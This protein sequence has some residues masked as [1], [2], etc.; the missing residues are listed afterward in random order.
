M[1]YKQSI[2]L[3][4]RMLNDRTKNDKLYVSHRF[5]IVWIRA[6]SG[7]WNIAGDPCRVNRNDVLLLNN[8]EKRVIEQVRSPEDLEFFI[9]E[10]EPQFLFDSGLLPLFTK[11]VN[12]YA[13]RHLA[14]DRQ[15]LS[16]MEQILGERERPDRYSQVIIASS[17]LQLLAMTARRIGL[18]PEDTP[19]VNTVMKTVLTYIDQHY[20]ERISLQE[21]ADIAHMS[22]TAFSRTFTKYNGIGP[23]QYI[24]RK[25]ILLATRLLEETDRTIVDIAM[26]CGYPNMSNFYKAFYSLTRRVPGSYR[27]T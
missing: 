5:K 10:F 6:G 16:I 4:S 15:M 1:N 11:P 21:L 2:W 8:K 12:G 20:T 27:E 22:S 23:A 26:E 14:A 7:L 19:R 17:V 3:S 18:I 24:K 25:R 9:M 13:H